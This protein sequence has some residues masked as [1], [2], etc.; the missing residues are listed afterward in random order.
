MRLKEYLLFSILAVFIAWS[1]F[2]LLEPH[3]QYGFSDVDW[4][5]LSTYKMQNPYK[6]SQFIDNIKIGGT[7]GG[8]YTH[9]IYYIGIQNEFFGL[10]FE[11]FR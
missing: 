1:Q 8:V 10:N 5:F 4:G 9:Q 2:I 11:S 6:L 7:T 3:L